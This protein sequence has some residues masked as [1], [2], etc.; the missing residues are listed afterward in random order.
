M[1]DVSLSPTR[2]DKNLISRIEEKLN[3]FWGRV[4]IAMVIWCSLAYGIHYLISSLN[5][6][7]FDSLS[8]RGTE[9]KGKVLEK[10]PNNHETVK[11][12]FFVNGK[13]YINIGHAGYGNPPFES[14]AVGQNVIVF[15]D[16]MAPTNSAL[17]NPK[18]ERH[19]ELIAL[20]LATIF[21]PTFVIFRLIQKGFFDPYNGLR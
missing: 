15:Y 14:L 8:K 20:T 6:P 7:L 13:E 4:A 2:G 5:M 17:G 12:S 1:A 18:D 21:I 3:S 9:T 16:P 11:F 19:N 10:F